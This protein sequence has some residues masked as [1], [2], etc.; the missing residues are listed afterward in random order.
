MIDAWLDGTGSMAGNSCFASLDAISL[1][2][3]LVIVMDGVLVDGNLAV[4]GLSLDFAEDTDGLMTL[5]G[6]FDFGSEQTAE[7]YTSSLPG[8]MEGLGVTV[9]EI[10]RDDSSLVV[11]GTIGTVNAGNL[12]DGLTRDW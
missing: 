12:V 8:F 11:Q 4:A 3:V 2:G 7:S 1:D 9:T 10:S 6:V 5:E